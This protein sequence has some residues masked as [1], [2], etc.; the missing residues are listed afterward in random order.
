MGTTKYSAA[1]NPRA[2][3]TR[4]TSK[5]STSASMP[6]NAGLFWTM[7]VQASSGSRDSVAPAGLGY[8]ALTRDLKVFWNQKAVPFSVGQLKVREQSHIARHPFIFGVAAIAEQHRA[9]IAG[10]MQSPLHQFDQ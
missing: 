2:A 4:F 1:D 7:F 9:G 5:A 6:F 10:A 3:P 8:N